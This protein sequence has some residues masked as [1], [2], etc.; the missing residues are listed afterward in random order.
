MQNIIKNIKHFRKIKD[1]S[2][3]QLEKESGL[4]TGYFWNLEHN[5]RN[6]PRLSTLVR[7]GN[8]LGISLDELVGTDYISVKKVSNHELVRKYNQLTT[9]DRQR[10]RTIIKL[11]AKDK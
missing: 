4:G 11:W 6:D 1:I 2:I 3:K 5:V 10:I 8:V 9:K 7:V